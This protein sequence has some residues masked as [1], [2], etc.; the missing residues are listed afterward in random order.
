MSFEA[1]NVNIPYFH[2]GNYPAAEVGQICVKAQ[3]TPF[4][5]TCSFMAVGRKE[6]MFWS[7][8]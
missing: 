4:H 5:G 7:L 3:T 1:T 2:A 6:K 8:M